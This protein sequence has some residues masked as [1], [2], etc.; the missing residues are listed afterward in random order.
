MGE[1]IKYKGNEI[2][3]GT[4]ESLYYTSYQKYERALQEGQLSAVRVMIHRKHTQKL[5]PVT[6]FGFP[7]QM[8]II[9][10]LEI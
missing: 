2:K 4:C 1:Y 5:T 7:F 10:L 9:C 6:G 8:K 3:I